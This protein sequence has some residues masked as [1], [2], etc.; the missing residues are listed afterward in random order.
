MAPAT[1]HDR[2]PE[3]PL[4]SGIARTR[5]MPPR[6]PVNHVRRDALIRFVERG[7]RRTLTLVQAPAGFGKT[8]VLAEWRRHLLQLEHAVAWLAIEEDDNDPT[9]LLRSILTA[10]GY[11]SDEI[12]SAVQQFHSP[13]WGSDKGLLISLINLIDTLR[14]PI[15]LILDDYERVQSGMAHELI[16]ELLLNGPHN[17]H[18]IIASRERPALPISWLHAH[19]QI[20]EVDAR[21]LR[22][23]ESDTRRFI[24]NAI[25]RPLSTD[26][27]RAVH[28]VTEGWIAGLLMLSISLQ[29]AKQPAPLLQNHPGKLRDIDDYLNENVLP[30][31]EPEL[32]A[33]MLD[34]SIVERLS[35]PLCQA[36]TQSSEAKVIGHLAA[37]QRLN[38]FLLALDDDGEWFRYHGLF[39]D[40]LRRR[41]KAL[42]PD[43]F[44]ERH[45]RAANWFAANGQ[46]QEA[47]R[48][49]LAA[50]NSRQA[51]AWVE[52][53]A[54]HEV[55]RGDM[56]QVLLW[57]R[58]LPPET[59]SR[60]IPL[61]LAFAW[62]NALTTN[63]REASAALDQIEHQAKASG[64]L[65]TFE[66]RCEISAIRSVIFAFSDSP[67]HALALA[68]SCMADLTSPD[69]HAYQPMSWV[70]AV[71][72]NVVTFGA[73]RAGNLDVARAVQHGR[74]A[75]DNYLFSES[76]RESMLAWC[77]MREGL[78]APAEQ[79]LQGFMA[80]AEREAG[81]RSAAAALPAAFLASI[82][83]EWNQLDRVERLLAGRLDVI[84]ESCV[85]EAIL[86]SY[87]VLVSVHAAHRQFDD[88][89]RLLDTAE[90]IAEKSV[91]PR[92]RCEYIAQRIWLWH[93][94]DNDAAAQRA[95]DRLHE[96]IARFPSIDD[97]ITM[98]EIQRCQR[99]AEARVLLKAGRYSAAT[100]LLEGVIESD[101]RA[102]RV[103]A[104]IVPQLL[105][106][107]ANLHAGDRAG[108]I[109]NARRV[110]RAAPGD[111]MTRTLIDESPLIAPL[112]EA[113]ANASRTDDAMRARVRTVLRLAAPN[114]TV[115][116]EPDRLESPT[117]LSPRELAILRL[118]AAGKTNKYIANQ[119]HITSATVKWHLSN[120]F[121]KLEVGNRT[122]AVRR[123][124]ALSL[125]AID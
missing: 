80:Q 12:A 25:S 93:R 5:F 65:E 43:G 81:A 104:T 27:L 98:H 56:R 89:H 85:C 108:A 15:V 31:I 94:Q 46:W 79:R 47:V 74:L 73:A 64:L 97:P 9:H 52:V 28:A 115:P 95:L 103:T 82:H 14:A 35:I 102:T 87:T 7:L 10:L 61:L 122:L 116:V 68:T 38:L 86:A 34:T 106:A 18:L 124:H 42:D 59:M 101:Q 8:T 113:L 48:H 100:A 40:F 36:L 117:M 114:P 63:L 44:V 88:A 91:W 58:R 70:D 78:F 32:V 76:Y 66:L 45:Q 39:A 120:I 24:G 121:A 99:L 50:G 69:R 54:M 109:A 37:L 72:R 51:V 96:T 21:Q 110:L 75:Q 67:M 26:E 83:Y 33:F 49:A 53:Q 60:R 16:S 2:V 71:V 90:S 125:I 112:L 84:E 20:V 30:Y 11:A 62:A 92:L 111:A 118:V 1:P 23:D 19:D 105:L 57:Q 41:L 29:D 119:L 17:L 3:Y 13:T 4:T 123:A 77:D 22:F 55:K 107:T 6:D